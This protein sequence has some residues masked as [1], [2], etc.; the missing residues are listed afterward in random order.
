MH[1][2]VV[3]CVCA[4]TCA[5]AS[6]H[7]NCLCHGEWDCLY[8][9]LLNA[10]EQNSIF[11]DMYATG[12]CLCV[13]VN[14][15]LVRTLAT[16]LCTQISWSRPHPCPYTTLLCLTCGFNKFCALPP[17]A[18]RLITA[19]P[20]SALSL[21]RSPLPSTKPVSRCSSC[22]KAVCGECRGPKGALPSR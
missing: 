4:C 5:C 6:V 11:K 15:S 10:L 19:S 14:S 2:C 9:G 8:N 16:Q 12:N 21:S 20:K 18:A 3:V 7:V 1:M 17:R 13:L 22:L